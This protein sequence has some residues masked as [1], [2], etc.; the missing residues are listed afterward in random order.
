MSLIILFFI[1]RYKF[2]IIFCQCVSP[3][4][5]QIQAEGTSVNNVWASVITPQ[6][7]NQ[8]NE[9]GYSLFPSSVIH[10]RQSNDGQ[11]Q[12]KFSEFTT[13]GEYIFTAKASDNSGFIHE[14]EPIVIVAGETQVFTHAKYE[15]D[16][17][18]LH[19][20]AVT[21]YNANSE[22]DIYQAEFNLLSM[23]PE[24]I[25]ELD[26]ESLQPASDTS[27]VNFANYDS[28]FGTVY[29]PWLEV[30]SASDGIDTFRANLQL[31]PETTPLQFRV[32]SITPQH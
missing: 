10:L 27:L 11:W 20:P 8:R 25:L 26:M 31:I 6:M 29:I 22:L 9:H 12:G 1:K 19:L 14:A 30:A 18:R 28:R 2:F 23:G 3:I 17:E 13:G 21:V 32:E 5:V 16:T 24:I 7:V 4:S 15:V